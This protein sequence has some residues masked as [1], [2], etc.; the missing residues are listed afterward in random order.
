MEYYNDT[1]LVEDLIIVDECTG[2]DEHFDRYATI[3]PNPVVGNTLNINVNDPDQV[4]S[5]MIING[6]GQVIIS[7]KL[8][9]INN[10]VNISNLTNGIYIVKIAFKNNSYQMKK[11]IV[12]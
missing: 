11:L 2:I 7:E 3:Y 4:E 6:S 8:S 10:S 1:L 5:F 12:K 9:G